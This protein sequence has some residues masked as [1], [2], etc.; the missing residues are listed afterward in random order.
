MNGQKRN[1]FR[2]FLAGV[3]MLLSF[4]AYAQERT[5]TGKVY[6]AAGEP[7]IGAS[8]VIQGT[9]QGTIT[10]I[11]GAFQLKVQP[12]QTLVVSFLGYKDVILP[13]GNKNDFKVTLEE[14]SKKL[15]EVVVVGY[16]TQ[17]K[18]N[19]TGSVASVSS[20]DIQDIPVA[21][22]A[23]LLQGRLPGL[24]LTQNGAQAGNDNPEIRIRGIGTFGNNNPMV[25]IDGVEG[26]LS[27]ISEIPSADIDNI[28]VLKDAASAAIY[29]VRAANGVILITTKRGQAS[30]RVKV[31]YSG[32]YTLQTPGIVPDYIDSYNWALMRNEVN[33][34][35]FSP[36]ALQRLKDGSDPDHYA[37]T[38]WLDA[39]LRNASMHQHHLS[40]SG[41]SEN[42]HF[43]TSVAYSNQE[44]IMM[45]TGVERFSF[46][47][48]LDTRY[49][50]FTFGLNLSGNKNNV[51]APAVAPSGE[52]GIMRFVSWFTRP[53]VPVMYSNGHYGYVDGSSM[54]A[55]MV[56][57]PVELMS[58]GHR[59]NEYWRF[60][61]KAFAGIEL[62]DGLKFQT[63]LAYAFDLNATKSYT[64]KSPARYDAD[65][66]IVK[67]A[68]E[69]NKEE[70]YWYRNATWTN[71]N[72]LTY[73]KQFNKH[74]IN[75]LLGHSVIGS[76]FYKTTASIQGFPT[77]N[78][79]ELKGGTINPGATGESEE[80]KLQSFFGRVN[81]SYDD[82]Y[83]FEFNIR[84]DGSS[85]MPKA[86]RYA[87]FPS[88]SA[89]WVFSNEG[90]MKDYRNFSLGKLRLS[91][92]KLGNQEIGNYAYAAT[93]GASGNYFFDQSKDK[94]AGMVQTSVPNENIKW[95][96]TRSVNVAL[97]LGFFNNRIQ[98]T[99]EWFDKKTSDILMQL[100]MPGIFLG[101]LSAPYQNVGAV[102]N[103][104]WE[105]T[106][107]YSDSKGDWAWNVGFN[108]S[109]VKNEILEMGELEEKIDG[110]TINRI[111]NP[112]GAYFGYKAI[113]IYRTEADLQ[114]TNSKGEVIKQNGV[115]P[116][117]G[118]IMYADLDDNGNITPEDRDII[119]N[120][121]PKYSYSFNLG[122]SWKNF[123]LS[124]FW[125]GVGGIYRYSWETSTDIRG[126]LT[127]RWVNRY[128][129]DN[130][131]APM[132]A[133][134]NTMNDSY[135]SFWLEKSNYLRLKNLEF[136]YTFRQTELAKV[137]ISSIRVYFAG[138]NLLTF[139]PL[140][141]WDP[142]KSSGDTRNDVHPN[143]RTYSFGLNI[144]F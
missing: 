76:R 36:E 57:N 123:D 21:N 42:T 12:S 112:I 139:T 54:S 100:A 88:L 16:A 93:L 126:N 56:K 142:E 127:N 72:L 84:H 31:S 128:S 55:E 70:D 23:T 4:T 121:F 41:G 47:S 2:M 17:K 138:S 109:H 77:E 40:V 3:L 85:R 9:T 73:N 32:S 132:P 64:P 81:Y 14:D 37:N 45:K 1:L 130:I 39:V 44:G 118:D 111:G 59:S 136:G 29:G 24:V 110:N 49:K 66:N 124:T 65:G 74:N 35:T 13:V 94:Q 96:T 48:N 34:D 6:D 143:M 78:I 79:Y 115:A 101:S 105:W 113:G 51:T 95:E 119:G 87:T 89:G 75:V 83:L 140:K 97:D 134:G 103:R 58:L 50:R 141:N 11:D 116:K 69:T 30:S 20:K 67:A 82:R 117:L 107:N 91:W 18:V 104:G 19:L 43:M 53:T 28:S 144:Q 38:N 22:T 61:G 25:L 52:G 62:W 86:N 8:V 131:N 133:L 135:S 26:S 108:L 33:P 15:D 98:T 71:E 106:V 125:Q 10:D 99:F 129:A 68:G 137:G 60:N 120:P 63:S 114:R 7:I 92:G 122:A 102:R 90:F 80:Y 46:R 5:V 27:Q